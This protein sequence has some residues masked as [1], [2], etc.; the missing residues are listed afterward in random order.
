M[1]EPGREHASAGTEQ[2]GDI[3]QLGADVLDGVDLDA[4]TARLS[5]LPTAALMAELEAV[6]EAVAGVTPALRKRAS[7][8]DRLLARD[9]VAQAQ[10][11]PVGNRI[12]LGLS[13]AQARAAEVAAGAD[14]LG[15]QAVHL[16]QKIAELGALIEHERALPSGF[17]AAA[18]AEAWLAPGGARV[19]RLAHLEAIADS[20][21][22]CVAQITLVRSHAAQLRARHAQWRDLLV[23]LWRE[24]ATAEAAAARIDANGIARL[25]DGLQELA[26]LPSIHPFPSA[27]PRADHDHSKEPSP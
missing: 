19:R 20:W 6:L 8:W 12:R 26:A 13:S 5:Q 11:D 24:H 18:A 21:R 2:G 17:D 3:R 16:E 9:L 15:L 25:H 10:P 22:A 23:T 7:W 27:H 4:V 1:R 14:A